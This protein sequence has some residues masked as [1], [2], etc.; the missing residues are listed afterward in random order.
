[1]K[2][3]IS[4]SAGLIGSALIPQLQAK[5]HSVRRLVRSETSGAD[6]FR[7]DPQRGTLDPAALEGLDAVINLAGESIS[8]GRWTARKKAK[9]RE[10]RVRGTSLLC[11]SLAQL[12][13]RPRVLISSSAIG[14]YGDRGNEVLREDS[15]PGTGFLPEVCRAWEAATKR[16]EAMGIRVVH[17][18]TGIGL[19]AKGGALAKM[20]PPF[21]LGAGAVLGSGTQYF[22]WIDIEDMVQIIQ[23]TLATE[24]LRG[25]V[26]AVS[27]NPVTNAVFTKML[28]KVLKRP[29]FFPAP[30]PLVRIALGEMADALLLASAR[31]EPAKLIAAGYQFRY[32][33]LEGSLYHLLA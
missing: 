10:S 19:S 1:M 8:E 20:L 16:A 7:W 11:E 5:G 26:N 6:T 25:P 14:Y 21:K 30:A 17:L 13:N 9:I 31:V 28:A 12:M 22:S 3:L 2:I 18:R 24:T 29:A 32:P 27:P 23:L 33:E 4:G 15:G